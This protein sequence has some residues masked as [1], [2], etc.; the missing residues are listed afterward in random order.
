MRKEEEFEIRNMKFVCN[1]LN[2]IHR[3][4]YIIEKNKNI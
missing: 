1:S 2:K 4:E 3:N